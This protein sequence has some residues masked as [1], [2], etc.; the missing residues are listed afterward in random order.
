M[1]RILQAEVILTLTREQAFV[2]LFALGVA[3]SHTYTCEES[4]DV[5]GV[6]RVV[7]E[8]CVRQGVLW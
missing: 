7:L 8:Q 1:N 3:G 6:A 5:E 4:E 2:V